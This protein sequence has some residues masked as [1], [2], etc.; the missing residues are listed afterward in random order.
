[1][2][3]GTLRLQQYDAV[4][5]GARIAGVVTAAAL[6][7]LGWNVLVVDRARFPSDTL[8]THLFFSDTLL[9][10]QKVRLL[11]P[12]LGVDAP[13]I[14]E[15]RFPYVAA[16]LP[17]H[18][19]FDFALC[20]RRVRLDWLLLSELA[21]RPRVTIETRSEVIDVVHRDDRIAGVVVREGNT[22][23]V[24][25]TPLVIGADGRHSTIAK[26]VR[27]ST[28]HEVPRIFAW[29]YTYFR[30]IPQEPIA[31]A[32]RGDHPA[33]GAEYAAAF[34]FPCDQ[35]LTLV[36]YGVEAG[37]FD[38]FRQSVRRNFDEGLRRIPAVWQRIECGSQ[39]E[40][41]RG[42]GHLPNFFRQAAGPGWA[43]VGDAGC[44][45]DPHSVQ[46]IGDAARSALLLAE[47]LATV[48]PWADRLDEALDRYARRR[49]EDLLPMYDFT[50]FRLQRAVPDQVWEAFESRTQYDER[51]RRLRVAAMVH[52]IHPREIYAPARVIHWAGG[53]SAES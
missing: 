39:V 7:E 5:V 38:R 33:I 22:G 36:G 3:Q 44:H 52:A 19:G 34:I 8:S 25:H 14:R 27:A 4:V 11:D 29:Y 24:V 9:A 31:L 32:L 35:G 47:E 13:R 53:G 46:G 30:G 23:R 15:I 41:V 18:G 2:A 43:L 10:L 37:A 48:D 20:I 16:P 42:T 40:Q 6:A 17:D 26:L 51:L 21:R 12:V 1:M 49:D 28:Y 45:K 50:T